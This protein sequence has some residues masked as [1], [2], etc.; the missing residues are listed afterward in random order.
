[1]A[2]RRYIFTDDLPHG[3][4]SVSG[5]QLPAPK[6]HQAMGMYV[7]CDK[8]QIVSSRWGASENMIILLSCL[9][10]YHRGLFIYDHWHTASERARL[11]VGILQIYYFL[12][13]I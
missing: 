1:M 6:K 5:E 3:V 13:Y 10:S 7:L 8:E 11:S 2:V 9:L 12:E 4:W